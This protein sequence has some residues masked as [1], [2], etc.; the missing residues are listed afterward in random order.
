METKTDISYGV[1]PL[2]KD[3]GEWKVLIVHQISYRGD[4]FWILPKGHAEEDES[5]LEAARRELEEETGVSAVDIKETP[6]FEI[7]YSFIHEGVRI[8]KAVIY[9]L[10]IC[11][12]RDVNISQ[13]QEIKELRWCAFDEAVTLVTHDNSR[14]V[15]AKAKNAL[16]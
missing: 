5:P 10:G 6:T 8:E 7:N 11:E 14:D 12:S 15:L 2:Y 16:Q 13:P 9:F 3:E 1:V 4:D